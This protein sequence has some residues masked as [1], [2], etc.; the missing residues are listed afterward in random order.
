MNL[1]RLTSAWQQYRLSNSMQRFNQA[2]ILLMLEVSEGMAISK[3]NKYLISAIMFI[4][5]TLCCQG[6]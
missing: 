4:V 1:N 5:L 6:G 3:S 2:E